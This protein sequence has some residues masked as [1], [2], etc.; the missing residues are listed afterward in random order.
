MGWLLHDLRLLDGWQDGT[1]TAHATRA[2]VYG[3]H[4]RVT[5]GSSDG[6]K[7]L[8]RLQLIL[9]ARTLDADVDAARREDDAA[10]GGA[11]EKLGCETSASPSFDMFIL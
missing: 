2:K 7:V 3:C 4:V 8:P 5:A 9:L 6:T 10:M 1:C 11:H